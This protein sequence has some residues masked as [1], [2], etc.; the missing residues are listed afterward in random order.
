MHLCTRFKLIVRDNCQ[1]ATTRN[2]GTTATTRNNGTTTHLNQHFCIVNL[3][4]FRKL[5]E[6]CTECHLETL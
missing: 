5:H 2:N 4:L 3:V 1:V 6:M